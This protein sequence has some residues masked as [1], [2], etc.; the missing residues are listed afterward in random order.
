MK[1]IFVLLSKM[2]TPS[3]YFR[4]LFLVLRDTPYPSVSLENID[5]IS[6]I[7]WISEYMSGFLVGML[8]VLQQE[9]CNLSLIVPGYLLLVIP[10]YGKNGAE[11]LYPTLWVCQ[12]N[13]IMYFVEVAWI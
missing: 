8:Y 11:V 1:I 9:F 4:F 7:G 13:K 5:L 12:R 10:L 2:A 3:T 6:R